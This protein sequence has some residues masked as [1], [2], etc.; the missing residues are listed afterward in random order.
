MA[1]EKILIVDDEESIRSSLCDLLSKSGYEVSA[2]DGGYRAIE[3]VKDGEW[4][5]TLLDLRMPGIDGMETLKE[6]RKLKSDLIIIIM[7]AY[8]TID[9]AVQAIQS[10]ANDYISKPFVADELLLRLESVLEKKRLLEEN[11][12]LRQELTNKY[13]FRNIIG[14]SKAMQEVFKLIERVAPTD[15]TVLIRGQSGT[16]KELIARAIHQ[17]SFRKDK[18]FIAVDCGALP[19]TL[20]E[21]E[22][23]GHVKGSFTD[24][25]VTKRGLLEVADGGTFFLDEVGDLSMGI[26]SKLL[27][28]LQEKEFR[29]VGGIKNIRVDVR[30]IAATN[31]DLEEMIKDERFRED[32]YYRLNIVPIYLSSLKE[33]KEDIPLLVQH[34]LEKYN[35]RRNKNIKGVSPGAMNILMDFDW[36]G[37]VRELENIMERLVIMTDSEIIEAEHIPA[38][39]QGKRVCFNI[40]TALTNIELKKLKQ[41]IRSQAVENVE[42][43]FVIN[44]LKRSDWNISKAARIVGMKRQNFQKLMNKYNIKP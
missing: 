29:Q 13:E 16:G 10:G 5:L 35:K 4:D 41:Q 3:K 24:A 26:Q 11:I 39:I 25:V 1:K 17:N 18:K 8:A 30:L 37:N 44:A 33:R 27:R 6:L 7:T 21:S 22:L 9:S 23:F 14:K 40:P 15:S 43:A 2:V 20:L 34:F 12:Y 42:K 19:E 32:L 31:K 36:P 38:H 28:V